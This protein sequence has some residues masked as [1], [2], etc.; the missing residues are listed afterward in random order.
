MKLLWF[1]N[2]LSKKNLKSNYCVGKRLFTHL[3]K[4]TC[5]CFYITLS[6]YMPVSGF[7]PGL[8]IGL[9]SSLLITF[10]FALLQQTELRPAWQCHKGFHRKQVLSCSAVSEIEKLDIFWMVNQEQLPVPRNHAQ[11]G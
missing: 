6:F 2:F 1:S 4:V 5:N 11:S 10:C 7:V 9:Q 8:E 3:K